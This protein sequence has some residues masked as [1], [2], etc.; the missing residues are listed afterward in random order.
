MEHDNY[1]IVNNRIW[2]LSN[3]LPHKEMSDTDNDISSL[4]FL[5]NL[6][7]KRKNNRLNRFNNKL[8]E[9]ISITRNNNM[10]TDPENNDKI[11]DG[12]NTVELSPVIDLKQADLDNEG[13]D[14]SNDPEKSDFQTEQID[15]PCTSKNMENLDRDSEEWEGLSNKENNR[16]K[17]PAHPNKK[18]SSKKKIVVISSVKKKISSKMAAPKVGMKIPKLQ[19]LNF[20]NSNYL[21]VGPRGKE[22]V[23]GIKSKIYSQNRQLTW[24]TDDIY[25]REGGEYIRKITQRTNTKI[26]NFSEFPHPIKERQVKLNQLQAQ[27]LSKFRSRT[28]KRKNKGMSK[29]GMKKIS[30]LKNNLRYYNIVTDL[31]KKQR[32]SPKK[33]WWDFCNSE[34]VKSHV[35]PTDASHLAIS[36]YGRTNTGSVISEEDSSNHGNSKIIINKESKFGN[37]IVSKNQMQLSRYTKTDITQTDTKSYKKTYSREHSLSSNRSNWFSKKRSLPYKANS[38]SRSS[39]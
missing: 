33:L 23:S 30:P 7:L 26:S 17:K 27:D 13:F 15:S 3:K 35:D 10:L 28:V 1:S 39:K 18:L 5:N 38:R 24:K 22:S 34:I 20:M 32:V 6:S 31:Q 37:K 12:S 25:S 21:A 8:H 36:K 9:K 14:K 19:H 2:L 16:F 29:F 4:L 11:N